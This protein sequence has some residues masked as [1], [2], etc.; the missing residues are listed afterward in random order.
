MPAGAR[1]R[2]RDGDVTPCLRLGSLHESRSLPR[3]GFKARAARRKKQ[4][5][6]RSESDGAEE[7]SA[8]TDADAR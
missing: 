3:P 8:N 7:A 5:E 2:D 1:H 4:G 6:D